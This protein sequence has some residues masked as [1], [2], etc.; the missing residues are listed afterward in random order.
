M[1]V[2][3]IVVVVVVVTHLH[4]L[5]VHVDLVVAKPSCSLRSRSTKVLEDSMLG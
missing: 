4:W 1:L 5:L 2:L 3:V